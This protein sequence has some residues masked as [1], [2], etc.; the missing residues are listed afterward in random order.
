VASV[1]RGWHEWQRRIGAAIQSLLI[2]VALSIGTAQNTFA[3]TPVEV[4]IV[5]QVSGTVRVRNAAGEE[6]ALKPFGRVYLNDRFVLAPEAV[7]RVLFLRNG[8]SQLWRGPV[9]FLA[10]DSAN[11]SGADPAQVSVLPVSAREKIQVALRPDFFG[12]TTVRAIKIPRPSAEL[13]A[14]QLEDIRNTYQQLRKSFPDDDI[15]PELFL[16]ASMQPFQP[17]QP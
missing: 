12:G 2:V 7:V 13:G 9:E 1:L 6:T 10:G 5:T 8:S 11:A 4:G 14:A 17:R 15:T 16:S 3:Q